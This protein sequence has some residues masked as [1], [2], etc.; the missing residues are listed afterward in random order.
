MIKSPADACFPLHIGRCTGDATGNAVSIRA[1][2]RIGTANRH[3]A[4]ICC[5]RAAAVADGAVLAGGRTEYCD[6]PVAAT[7]D[8]IAIAKGHST[9]AVQAI[10]VKVATHPC[11]PRHCAT[12]TGDAAADAVTG[13]LNHRILTVN[14]HITDIRRQRTTAVSDGTG[15]PCWRTVD[16]H[17][18][19]RALRQAGSRGKRDRTVAIAAVIANRTVNT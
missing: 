9:I 1:D 5:Q 7:G 15:L 16:H 14:R 12:G 3:I 8:A 18:P 6:T 19:G 2:N 4:D 11:F 10:V 13:R 17:S